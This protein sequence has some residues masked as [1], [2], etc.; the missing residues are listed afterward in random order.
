MPDFWEQRFLSL[1]FWA[2]IAITIAVAVAIEHYN[3]LALLPAKIL[4]TD[5]SIIYGAVA[6]IFGSLL[7]FVMATVPIV[8]AF[9]GMSRLRLLRETKQYPTMWRVFTSAIRWLGGATIFALVAMVLDR[10]GWGRI[11]FYLCVGTALIAVFRVMRCVWVLE[12]MVAVIAKPGRSGADTD[13][14]A[15]A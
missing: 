10:G 5:R 11:T 4:L 12:Q 6:S 13:G 8:F 2:G 9:S 1:E 7:G 15:G 14:V 3:A